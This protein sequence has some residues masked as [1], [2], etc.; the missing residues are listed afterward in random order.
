PAPAPPEKQPRPKRRRADTTARERALL[1]RARTALGRSQPEEALAALREHR[2]RFKR[3]RLREER[4]ALVVAA[5]SQLGRHDE[6]AAAA[7]RF[8]RRYPN[9]LFGPMV[10]AAMAPPSSR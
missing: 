3:G 7:R 4:A 10:E 6:A 9:S 5:L 2:T 8:L 1:E